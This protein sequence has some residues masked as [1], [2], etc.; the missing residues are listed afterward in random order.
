MIMKT[1]KLPD[2]ITRPAKKEGEEP[3]VIS[4]LDIRQ[5]RAGELRNLE[6]MSI[7]R[8]DYN[9]HKTLIPRICP[10]ITAADIDQMTPRNLLAIQQEIVDFFMA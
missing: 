10:K 7:I 2:P 3:V 6:V 1:V 5:P 4:E 8:M 9:S